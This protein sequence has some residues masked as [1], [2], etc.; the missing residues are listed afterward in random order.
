M[1]L[2]WGKNCYIGLANE[3]RRY[4]LDQMGGGLWK[5]RLNGKSRLLKIINPTSKAYFGKSP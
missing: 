5:L 1:A 2:E 3:V 4:L